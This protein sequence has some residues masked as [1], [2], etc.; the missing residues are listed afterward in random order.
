MVYQ[1]FTSDHSLVYATMRW[2]SLLYHEGSEGGSVVP[3]VEIP[4]LIRLVERGRLKL[5]GLFT[6]EYSLDEINEAIRVFRSG[7]A[8]RMLINVGN[9]LP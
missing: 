9:S 8:G 4:R 6:H 3:D 5:D 2:I 1:L 7:E